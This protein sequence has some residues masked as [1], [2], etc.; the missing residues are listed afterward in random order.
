[1]KSKK[2]NKL[3]FK[4][5]PAQTGLVSVGSSLQSVD[6]KS[7]KITVGLIQAPNWS[8]KDSVYTVCFQVTVLGTTAARVCPWRWTTLKAT[9]STEQEARDFVKE[10]WVQIHTHFNLFKQAD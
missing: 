8:S 3:S 4:K 7:D 9:F 6:I 10:K 5:H 1:M 2:I